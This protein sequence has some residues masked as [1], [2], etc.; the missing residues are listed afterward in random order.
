MANKKQTK[1]VTE[2]VVEVQ[3]GN[4]EESVDES[5]LCIVDDIMGYTPYQLD[6]ESSDP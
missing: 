3:V 5:G 2:D 6:D 4:I 1:T